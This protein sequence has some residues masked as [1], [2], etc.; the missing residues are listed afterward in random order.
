MLKPMLPTLI[1][2]APTGQNWVY[3]IKY[4][5]FRAMLHWEKDRIQLISRNGNLLNEQFP[6]IIN[7][8][9]N[10]SDA[11][12]P[13]LPLIFDGELCILESPYKASFEYIQQRGRLRST[14]KI[15]QASASKPA[16]Y[17]VF[18]LLE[19]GGQ[20]LKVEPFQVRKDELYKLF[21]K[22]NLS[23]IINP[24]SSQLIQ[25]IKYEEDLEAIWKNAT[26]QIAEGIIAKK[27]DS[28][29]EEGKRTTNWY[30][31]KNWQV[32]VFFI[33]GY[34]K[35][36]AYFHVGVI[37]NNQIYEAG[38]FSHGLS[39]DERQALLQVIQTN[40]TDETASFIKVGPG[41][42]VELFYLELY[43]EQLRQPS[44][45][46]FRFD[47]EWQDCTWEKL[48]NNAPLL[49]KE[50]EITHPDKPLWKDK[51]ITKL[52]YIQYLV[53][54]SPNMLPFLKERLLT[55]IR[56]PH[57]MYGESFYQ[58]NCPEY[59]PEF[60]QT[61]MSDGI[62]YIVCNDLKTLSWLGNQLSFEF[63]IPFRTIHSKGPSEI[64]FDLDPP[65]RAAFPL[66][67][68]AA[69]ILK[70]VFDGLKLISFVKTSGNKG[71]Q[72]YIP[73]PENKFTYE[74]TRQFTEFIAN[75]LVTMEPDLFTTERLKK[76]RGNR[77]YVDYVQHA[78]GKTIVAPYSVRG[79]DG[80]YVATP[81]YWEEITDELSIEDFPLETI[82]E[83]INQN[84]CP[85]A[86]YFDAKEKQPFEPVLEFLRQ[87]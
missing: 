35:K 16:H 7:Q 53:E 82:I 13:Y 55:V 3:E 24:N 60:I 59:A 4:D 58:K 43:K 62:E 21:S 36:N 71:L 49:P 14:D 25:L 72:I 39:P 80:A 26:E 77:M 83:R 10:L 45:S 12:I 37:R 32:G 85:F 63:H 54:V 68:K 46:Q 86:H 64:V 87:S 41:I 84:G 17:L 27:I 28:T 31:I 42:C 81:L 15:T 30:K 56:Y 9:K 70:E 50:I 69:T 48:S 78:E 57:G 75:Y 6:E 66:A 47:V 29:W 67:K 19:L 34:D 73:L 22:A 2:E 51:S 33:L 38:L 40:S 20:D 8:C 11:M 23:H 52:D 1:F 5:G 65:S 44:F 76:N 61:S 79:N 18:D 74:D